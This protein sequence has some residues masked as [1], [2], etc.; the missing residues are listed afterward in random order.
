MIA[1][2]ALPDRIVTDFAGL[3][4][5]GPRQP[6]VSLRT[7]LWPD[8]NR[9]GVPELRRLLHLYTRLELDYDYA[10]W[11]NPLSFSRSLFLS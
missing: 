6:V 4:L 3:N 7:P 10:W 9:H 1:L 5:T 2:G 8:N 11:L